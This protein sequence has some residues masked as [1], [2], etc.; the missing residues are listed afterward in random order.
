MNSTASA[1][2]WL[3]DK[4]GQVAEEGCGLSYLNTHLSVVPKQ[5]NPVEILGASQ[6]KTPCWA[7][8]VT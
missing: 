3:P 4:Q 1:T 5:N 7:L 8:L 2:L 6:F